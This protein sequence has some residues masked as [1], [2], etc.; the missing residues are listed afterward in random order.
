[1]WSSGLCV[2]YYNFCAMDS[3]ILIAKEATIEA[4]SVIL[5]YNKADYKIC[6]R[7]NH[8]PVKTA[9]YA[10]YSRLKEILMWPHRLNG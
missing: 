2:F 7:G 4:G 5:T 3:D 1:M 10:I 6:D 8:N 9:D